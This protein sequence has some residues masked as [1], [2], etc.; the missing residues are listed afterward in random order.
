MVL[1]LIAWIVLGV[2]GIFSAKYRSYAKES[3]SCVFKTITLRKCDSDFDQ[4]IKM[5]ISGGLQKLHPFLAR[6]FYQNYQLISW[7]FVILFFSSLIY[8]GYS[9][10][11]LAVFGTCE[12]TNPAACV[13]TPPLSNVPAT[14]ANN[15]TPLNSDSFVK[16]V[17]GIKDSN[18]SIG[19]VVS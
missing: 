4:K 16:A 2:M 17:L 9:L 5:K 14:D 13:F 11:N 1:C 15:F 18:C 19:T 10:Y 8:S 6:V 3:F 7:I 12:P